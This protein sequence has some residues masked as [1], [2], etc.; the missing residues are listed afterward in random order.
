MPLI[1][2]YSMCEVGVQMYVLGLTNGCHVLLLDHSQPPSAHWWNFFIATKEGNEADVTAFTCYSNIFQSMTML[3]SYD[4]VATL[5]LYVC[6][7]LC[8]VVMFWST[9]C[10]SE[11]NNHCGQDNSYCTDCSYVL[12]D[13]TTVV[14]EY[15]YA[16]RTIHTMYVHS[17]VRTHEP[18]S[19]ALCL[20][21]QVCKTQSCAPIVVLYACGFIMELLPT[22]SMLQM[23]KL[24]WWY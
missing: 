5:R 18:M 12:T 17:H 23:S 4:H 24:P 14:Y 8:H 6:V 10:W 15:M 11:M 3:M 1:Y 16:L 7:H 13:V 20:S 22:Y 21:T 2:M 19:P 9:N